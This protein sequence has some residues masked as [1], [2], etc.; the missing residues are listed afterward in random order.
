MFSLISRSWKSP[1]RRSRV[2][3]RAARQRDEQRRA[4][5]GVHLAET[6]NVLWGGGCFLFVCMYVCACLHVSMCT[7]RPVPKEVSRGCGSPGAVATGCC[8][9]SDMGAKT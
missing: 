8:E 6:S 2:Q 4:G 9:S 3:N 7:C 1:Y 5:T